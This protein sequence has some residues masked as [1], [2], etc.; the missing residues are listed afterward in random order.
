MAKIAD[1]MSQKNCLRLVFFSL[2]FTWPFSMCI[3]I[4]TESCE[5]EKNTEE[6][7]LPPHG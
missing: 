5:Q 3:H 7:A 1:G 4:N 2:F 6:A